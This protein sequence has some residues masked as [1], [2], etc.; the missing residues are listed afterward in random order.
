VRPVALAAAFALFLGSAAWHLRGVARFPLGRQGVQANRARVQRG[1][2]G[3]LY[4]GAIL[5]TGLITAMATP[6]VYAGAVM[7]I[8]AG[9]ARALAYG[10]SFGIGR[11]V[12][13][14]MGALLASRDTDPSHIVNSLM[15]PNLRK[16]RVTG[17][18]TGL[19]GVG[20]LL[21]WSWG[22]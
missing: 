15:V 16:Y 3:V 13:A 7:A 20:V 10:A 6:L 5:G 4:F 18:L 8:Y 12:P 17:V 11:S 9:P 2:G 19:L 22:F 21:G 14:L 1:R